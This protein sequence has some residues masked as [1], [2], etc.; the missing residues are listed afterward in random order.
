M[1]ALLHLN[2]RLFKSRV[3]IEKS[4]DERISS[5]GAAYSEN[6]FY[7]APMEPEH[8][9]LLIILQT[10]CSSGAKTFY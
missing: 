5:I 4:D 8:L 9:H 7:V 2:F 3:F 1:K 6:F 10:R